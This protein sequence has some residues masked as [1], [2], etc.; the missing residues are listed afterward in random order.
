M[1]DLCSLTDIINQWVR[2]ESI[3]KYKPNI[4]SDEN[5]IFVYRKEV[6]C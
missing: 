4:I 1:D 2:H 6:S 3:N 5:S